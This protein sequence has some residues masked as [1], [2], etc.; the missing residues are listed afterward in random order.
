MS[1]S[2]Q[3]S[4]YSG[5]GGLHFVNVVAAVGVV[6]AVVIDSVAANVVA[7]TWPSLL[8]LLLLLLMLLLLPQAMQVALWSPNLRAMQVAPPGGQNWNEYK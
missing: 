5:G 4:Q 1:Q 7:V 3:V 8:L 6:V 2:V